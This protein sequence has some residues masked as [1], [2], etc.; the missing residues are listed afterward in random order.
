MYIKYLVRVYSKEEDSFNRQYSITEFLWRKIRKL[1]FD[2]ESHL[3]YSFI[4]IISYLN[5]NPFKI[6]N[7]NFLTLI[8]SKLDVLTL[9]R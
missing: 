3:I 6:F 7:V 4:L 5:Q 9:Y 2:L 1:T 8:F